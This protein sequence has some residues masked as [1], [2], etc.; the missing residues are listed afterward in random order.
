MCVT[1]YLS[2]GYLNQTEEE[3]KKKKSSLVKRVNVYQA[4]QAALLGLSSGSRNA[5]QT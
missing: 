3:K 5:G 2:C 4:E 1:Q